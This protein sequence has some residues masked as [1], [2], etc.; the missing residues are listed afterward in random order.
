MEQFVALRPK[1]WIGPQ[2]PAR[3]GAEARENFMPRN[4]HFPADDLQS[5]LL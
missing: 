3:I 5:S 2:R 1:N 4:N